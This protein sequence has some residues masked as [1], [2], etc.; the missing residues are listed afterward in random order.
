MILELMPDFGILGKNIIL[1]FMSNILILGIDGMLGNMLASVFSQQ[2][3]GKLFFTSRRDKPINEH[4]KGEIINFD[5]SSIGFTNLVSMVQPDFVI[6][7]IG[8]IKP[9]IKESDPKS[10]I[11]AQTINSFLP[12]NIAKSANEFNF[13]YLQI[14]TDC[15]FNGEKGGYNE[16]SNTDAIDVYGKTKIA[17][18]IMAK[19]KTVIRSSIIGPEYGTGRSLL[20]W[21]YHEQ[22]DAVS[23]FN[24]HLWNG[25]T[26]L[27]FANVINGI[28]E[29]NYDVGLIQHL[30]PSDVVTKYEL[31]HLFAKYF[32]KDI[33]INKSEA[34]TVINRTLTTLNPQQNEI[35]WNFGGYSE[36]PSVEKNIEEL[37]RYSLTQELLIKQ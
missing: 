12:L 10:V 20:N 1:T 36:I 18:E 25:V 30:I 19:N 11:N 24:N 32:K 35:L 8:A 37:S 17:G 15:V 14:G 23:G 34:D 27:N 21:F 13:K 6:N 7:C 9:L 26:T 4:L 29:N 2:S 33:G 22:S 5:A 16:E 3:S 28:I 31:L